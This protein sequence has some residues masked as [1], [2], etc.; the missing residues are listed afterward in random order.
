VLV[1]AALEDV[2][3]LV[4]VADERVR[5]VRLEQTVLGFA[6]SLRRCWLPRTGMCMATITVRPSSTRARSFASQVSWS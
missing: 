1:D 3:A 2:L 4:R 6:R 5:L